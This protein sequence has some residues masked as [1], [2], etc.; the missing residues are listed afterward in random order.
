MLMEIGTPLH[1]P[2]GVLSPMNNERR[3][4]LKHELRL[5]VCLVSGN[6]MKA[7]EFQKQQC[8]SLS[9]WR[10]STKSQ[11]DVYLKIWYSFCC[12]RN[13]D[14]MQFSELTVVEFLSYL[15]EHNHGYISINTARSA[16]YPVL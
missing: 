7:E 9:S 13:L 3:H 11:Y 1:L 16:L 14:S 5:L 12:E 8:R 4:P 2:L 15:Y 6:C 10:P